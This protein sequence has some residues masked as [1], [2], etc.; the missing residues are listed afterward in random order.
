MAYD[1]SR[2]AGNRGDVWKHFIL[3]T[4][5][6]HLLEKGRRFIYRESHAGAPVHTLATRGEWRSGIGQVLPPPSGLEGHAYLRQFDRP[7]RADDQYPASWVQASALACSLGCELTLQLHDTSPSVHRA[8]SDYAGKEVHISR[9]AGF[10]AVQ[11][12]PAADLTLIDPPFTSR[13][14]WRLSGESV[15]HLREQQALFAVWY[16]VFWP[17]RPNTLVERAGA[18]GFEVLWSRMGAKPSQ[19]MKGCGVIVD[20]ETGVFLEPIPKPLLAVEGCR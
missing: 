4:V 1:H 19:T 11:R 18:P 17:T 14:D 2:K 7:L 3:L 10:A 5:L 9:T 12:N 15:A 16:P 13:R 8:L 6:T 20:P